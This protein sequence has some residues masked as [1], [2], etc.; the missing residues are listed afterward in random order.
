MKNNPL[1][2]I[3]LCT[4]NWGGNLQFLKESIE[5][6]LNQSF[7]NF[8]LIIINDCSTNME[9]EKII[10]E[11]KEKDN[12]IIYLFN[13]INLK[14]AKSRNKWM[15]IAKWK[16]ISFIDDDDIWIDEKKLEKQIDYME[17][18]GNVGICWTFWDIIDMNGN[19]ILQ[20]KCRDSDKK[21]RNTILQANQFCT[22]SVMI[23]NDENLRFDEKFSWFS[24]DY[25]LW[26]KI[27]T[28]YKF[29]NIPFPCVSYRINQYWTIRNN[30]TKMEINAL[31]IFF[32]YFFK[33]PN[34]VKAFIL[35]IWKIILPS[36]VT[37]FLINKI[38]K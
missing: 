26:C 3:I 30:W 14:Q 17:T 6:V 9:V 18:H 27:W 5:S 35:R 12:R 25:E 38:K 7:K 8:E 21:I 33:Y 19:I 16:Y 10:L 28:K 22:S 34:W 4:F 20:E 13:K 36:K 31:R 32:K 24:E 37:S 15:K 2:S 29:Y 11:Y 1:I 23:I